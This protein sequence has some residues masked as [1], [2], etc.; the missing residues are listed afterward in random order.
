VRSEQMAALNCLSPVGLPGGLMEKAAL[1]IS[2]PLLAQPLG[3][4]RWRSVLWAGHKVP[5]LVGAGLHLAARRADLVPSS[6]RNP[7]PQNT[8]VM[9][10][11]WGSGPDASADPVDR[12]L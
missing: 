3:L 6:A 10:R 1:Q 12:G 5:R 9:P 4:G 8:G 11:C 7:W 2:P